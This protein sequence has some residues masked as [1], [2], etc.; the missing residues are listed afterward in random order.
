MQTARMVWGR[1]SVPYEYFVTVQFELCVSVAKG[2]ND[3]VGRFIARVVGLTLE[4]CWHTLCQHNS[5][6]VLA[7]ANSTLRR[8]WHAF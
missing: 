2:G 3:S 5:R 8:C 1:A 7:R 6:E 4:Q